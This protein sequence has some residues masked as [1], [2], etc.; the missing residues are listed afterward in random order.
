MHGLGECIRHPAVSGQARLSFKQIWFIELLLYTRSYI[1]LFV[2]SILSTAWAE[3]S[4]YGA[5][6]ALE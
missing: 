5:H 4:G 3:C 2:Y 6:A 1:S